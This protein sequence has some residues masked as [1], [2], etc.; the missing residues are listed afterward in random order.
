MCWQSD[1]HCFWG[2]MNIYHV[3]NCIW[4]DHD[5]VSMASQH[6]FMK[7]L[8]LD[9]EPMAIRHLMN[10][11]YNTSK[12][13]G[14]AVTVERLHG[15]YNTHNVKSQRC[16]VQHTENVLNI[17]AYK[18]TKIAIYDETHNTNNHSSQW[19]QVTILDARKSIIKTLTSTNYIQTPKK[20][21]YRN[22]EEELKDKDIQNEYAAK[23]DRKR[24][25]E[26]FE[27]NV[28]KIN[29]HSIHRQP[30]EIFNSKL[31]TIYTNTLYFC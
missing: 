20:M 25:Y 14:T 11:R 10:N 12:K 23:N 21:P 1:D 4:S 7:R 24:R 5:S 17:Q 13:S 3:A 19:H 8:S 27:G 16:N 9:I 2:Y 30:T 6:G 22:M 18:K 29:G 26:L 31:T 28:N 15:Y